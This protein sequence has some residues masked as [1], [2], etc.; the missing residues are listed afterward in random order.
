MNFSMA[1]LENLLECP[2][3]R[4][5]PQFTP[6]HQCSNGHILC[7][8][9]RPKQ[10]YCPVCREELAEIRSLAAEQMLQKPSKPCQFAKFGCQARLMPNNTEYH[11]AKCQFRKVNC[12]VNTCRQLLDFDDL[13]DHLM[14]EHYNKGEIRVSKCTH[15]LHYRV[16]ESHFQR[17]CYMT[18]VLIE[19]GPDLHVAMVTRDN[20][21]LWH[22]WVYGPG[23][24]A[25]LSEYA[26]SIEVSKDKVTLR[27]REFSYKGPAVSIFKSVDDVINQHDGLVLT[28]K[29]LKTILT[30]DNYLEMLVDIN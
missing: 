21:G 10:K 17:S 19:A 5:V 25:Q 30:E 11:L 1:E 24:D 15:T 7:S 29:S 4:Y 18:P 20:N 13:K 8:D 27:K 2:S 14:T 3:C 26:V 12:P 28:D 23:T 22:I 6:I 9:C 16:T